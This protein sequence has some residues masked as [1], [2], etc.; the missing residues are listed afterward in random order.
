MSSSNLQAQ[1][2]TPMVENWALFR[3]QTALAMLSE[4]YA[5]PLPK[6]KGLKAIK[7]ASVLMKLPSWDLLLPIL[8]KLAKNK[9][10]LD[11]EILPPSTFT[12]NEYPF[13]LFANDKDPND[14]TDKFIAFNYCEALIELVA[15]DVTTAEEKA[16][17][18]S[19]FKIVSPVDENAKAKAKFDQRQATAA[20]HAFEQLPKTL[21]KFDIAKQLQYTFANHTRSFNNEIAHIKRNYPNG[22]EYL[23]NMDSTS[24]F[25]NHARLR[26][27][28]DQ[29]LES[30]TRETLY[31]AFDSASQT[32]EEF[33]FDEYIEKIE[34][35][36][37]SEG[38]TLNLLNAQLKTE[39]IH[40]G[41]TEA[42]KLVNRFDEFII[43]NSTLPFDQQFS[44]KEIKNAFILAIQ[45][46]LN[47]HDQGLAIYLQ[48]Q[49]GQTNDWKEIKKQFASAILLDDSVLHSECP[50][51]APCKNSITRSYRK[52]AIYDTTNTDNSS[53]DSQF[54]SFVSDQNKFNQTLTNK[55][56]QLVTNR[57]HNSSRPP[58][59]H[60][61]FYNWQNL[62]AT[63]FMKL[64]LEAETELGGEIGSKAA[65]TQNDP[66]CEWCKKKNRQ[67]SHWQL[68]CFDKFPFLRTRNTDNN[69]GQ[70]RGNFNSYNN[71]GGNYRN[72]GNQYRGNYRG[73]R[74]R[75]GRNY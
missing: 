30:Q 50:A 11:G 21:K 34:T 41:D 51:S 54:H 32:F 25:L 23:D 47:E 56:E 28:F 65:W 69:R 35:E 67:S 5:A 61:P 7:D 24:K 45:K 17:E 75:G 53:V 13:S 57:N 42:P 73:N 33:T 29:T 58:R 74:G 18:T 59:E 36:L 4:I 52:N 66:E 2:P 9:F 19:T 1:P 62:P 64:K 49:I 46:G 8:I 12:F 14:H 37:G 26:S 38:Q 27:T 10:P 3:R 16:K 72:G 39:H 20:Q 43:R 55:L 22:F 31:N 63:E 6:W 68:N 70:Q 40:K 15:I 44:A 71:R 60:N 48:K